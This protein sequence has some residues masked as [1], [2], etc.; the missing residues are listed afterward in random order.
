MQKAGLRQGH[1]SGYPASQNGRVVAWDGVAS[2][3]GYNLAEPGVMRGLYR[4]RP[5]ALLRYI[6]ASAR[7]IK[8][9][10][11]C[12]SRARVTPREMVTWREQ[13]GR[14]NPS[15]FHQGARPLGDD[16]DLVGFFQTT[17]NARAILRHPTCPTQVEGAA[18]LQAGSAP[19]FSG[20]G[21]RSGGRRCR[22]TDL[23]WSTSTKITPKGQPRRRNSLNLATI[24]VSTI[25]AVGDL[26]ERIQVEPGLPVP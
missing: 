13:S 17:D 1:A 18:I 23:N 8:V 24:E 6:R 21:P 25:G 26:G 4:L 19:P 14:V 10:G 12:W 3:P 5:A 16:R 15:A 9:S 7:W 11:L 22:S 20:P 2:G